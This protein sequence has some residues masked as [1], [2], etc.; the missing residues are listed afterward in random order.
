MSLADKPIISEAVLRRDQCMPG[1]RECPRWY[2]GEIEPGM[3]FAWEPDLPHARELVVVTRITGSPRRPAI[4]TRPILGSRDDEVWNEISRFR[5]AVV[6]TNM[7]PHE[8]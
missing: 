2:G 7:K 6:P 3:V 8:P 4:W 5:E 1:F